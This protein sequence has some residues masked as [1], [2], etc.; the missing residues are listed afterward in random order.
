V[1]DKPR[2]EE[3]L[4]QVGWG[5]VLILAE[6]VFVKP[7]N[8][9]PHHWIM[10]SSTDSLENLGLFIQYTKAIVF[11]TSSFYPYA[12]A[13]TSGRLLVLEGEIYS[14]SAQRR[15]PKAKELM[16]LPGNAPYA[17]QWINQTVFHP[18]K[19]W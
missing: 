17:G 9:F 7:D 3:I 18:H 10:P 16:P 12:Y 6:K 5:R 19:T 15:V 1:A 13:T 8:F 14:L 2:Q 11:F 4:V